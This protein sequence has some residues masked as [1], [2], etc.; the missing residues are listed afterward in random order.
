METDAGERE[1]LGP[2]PELI[3][4]EI[5]IDNV[6]VTVHLTAQEIEEVS[7]GKSYIIIGR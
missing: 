6:K 7:S 4:T 5:E 2:T 3:E 1:F